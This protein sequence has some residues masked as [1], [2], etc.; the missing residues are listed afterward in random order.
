M[1]KLEETMAEELIKPIVLSVFKPLVEEAIL[2]LKEA[3][4]K[5]KPLMS[6][7]ELKTWLG[8]STVTIDNWVAQ[9][10]PT[11][12]LKGEAYPKFVTKQV[13]EFLEQKSQ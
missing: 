11:L 13:L 10:L 8:V 5:V 9:G 7:S 12:Q 2:D 1:T 6:K 3:Y 4:K